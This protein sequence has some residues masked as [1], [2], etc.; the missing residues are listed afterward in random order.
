MDASCFAQSLL[1]CTVASSDE[2]WSALIKDAKE[3]ECVR[4]V[5][6]PELASKRSDFRPGMKV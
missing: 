1:T 5:R 4:S 3:G 2:K 6:A